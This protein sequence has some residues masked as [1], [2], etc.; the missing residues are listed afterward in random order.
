MA[1]R[2]T[3]LALRTGRSGTANAGD[4]FDLRV[5]AAA[6]ES[7]YAAIVRLVRAAETDRADFTRLADRY[8]AYFLP[9]S[10]SLALIAWLAS[11]NSTR[12]WP[13][14]S[15]RRRARSSSPHPSPSLRAS[16]GAARAGI[17]VK[18]AGALER[19]GGA[20]TVLL[21]KTGTLTIGEPELERIITV[22]DLS[23]VEA[24]RLAASLDQMSAHVL[25]DSLVSRATARG[26]S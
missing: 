1:A 7:A 8:A 14:W 20:R 18:G 22:G 16:R 21:D 10:L 26:S 25:A 13:S 3:A 12:V 23:A 6:A 24:L 4:T 17:I 5:T 9:F 19:L 11:G 15:W 2:G